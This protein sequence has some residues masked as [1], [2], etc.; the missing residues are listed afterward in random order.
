M[1]FS[2]SN[3]TTVKKTMWMRWHYRKIYNIL[4]HKF[5][6]WNTAGNIAQASATEN[7]STPTFQSE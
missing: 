1:Y 4:E 2:L 3:N 7:K 5:V 6:I